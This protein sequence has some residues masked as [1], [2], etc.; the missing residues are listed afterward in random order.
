[1]RAMIAS[2][3][4]N[5]STFK[6]EKAAILG[7]RLD[8]VTVVTGDVATRWNTVNQ[9]RTGNGYR[10]RVLKTRSLRSFATTQLIGLEQVVE[11]AR[12]SVVHVECE[13]WQVVAVQSV[14]LARRLG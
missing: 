3:S 5:G 12:P 7:P 4:A 6:D 14:R 13:P 9:S 10:V 11:E 1:M 8:G 2:L